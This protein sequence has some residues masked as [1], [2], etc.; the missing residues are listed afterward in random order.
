MLNR[1]SLHLGTISAGG[2]V[3]MTAQTTGEGAHMAEKATAGVVV[4]VGMGATA[5][6]GLGRLTVTGILMA[7]A[8]AGELPPTHLRTTLTV[9]LP[10]LEAMSLARCF[11]R[12]CSSSD[13]LT[14]TSMMTKSISGVSPSFQPCCI[15]CRLC[16]MCRL[17][18][19]YAVDPI[20]WPR[21]QP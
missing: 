5:A 18:P 7:M 15:R 9:A 14:K 11:P 16:G 10:A 21:V 4:V 2:E 20:E 12:R 3:T 1:L 13:T 19:I 6:M 17:H 8:M